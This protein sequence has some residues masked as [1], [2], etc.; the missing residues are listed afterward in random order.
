MQTLLGAG[1][2][3]DHN[4]LVAKICTRLKKM[5]RF[6]QSRTQWDLQ[7]L[8]VQRQRVQNILEEK[9]GAIGRDSGNVEMQWKNIKEYEIDTISDL[10]WK[11]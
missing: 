11:V 5:L 6:H 8:Y 7:K 10:D 9:I 1:I 3:S 2:D 4:L